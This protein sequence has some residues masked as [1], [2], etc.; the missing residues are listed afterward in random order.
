M[1]RS[2]TI[3]SRRSFLETSTAT[4]LFQAV[5][6]SQPN[7]LW[8]TTEDIG[9]HLHACGDN[10]SITPNLDRLAA[11]GMHLQQRVV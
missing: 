3:L 6:P 8:L 10:Y 5:R 2:T 1:S 9:P 7:I 4:P 11:R